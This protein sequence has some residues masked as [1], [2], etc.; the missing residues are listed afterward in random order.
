MI[1][2]TFELLFLLAVYRVLCA[3]VNALVPMTFPTEV[4]V[5]DRWTINLALET[6]SDV[7]CIQSQIDSEDLHEGTKESSVALLTY[8]L[9]SGFQFLQATA[10]VKRMEVLHKQEIGSNC[11]DSPQ[12]KDALD[13][14]HEEMDWIQKTYDHDRCKEW[15]E[16]ALTVQAKVR[17]KIDAMIHSRFCQVVVPRPM[18]INTL[19]TNLV[20]N[21]GLTGGVGFFLAESKETLWPCRRLVVLNKKTGE[22]YEDF[23]GYNNN[24]GESV[25]EML[26]L[27]P[28]EMEEVNPTQ[29]PDY[30]V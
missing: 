18:T 3:L 7:M 29:H 17:Q 8:V 24:E 12:T 5:N 23:S 28:Y 13:K 26:G 1:A 11:S 16:H 19:I 6:F 2:Y 9:M 20:I 27:H 30:L 15:S 21:L 10:V 4:L 25:K 22:Y 14:I